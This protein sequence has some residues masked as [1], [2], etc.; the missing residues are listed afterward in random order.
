MYEAVQ[1]A[2]QVSRLVGWGADRSEFIGAE[3]TQLPSYGCCPYISSFSFLPLL[4]EPLL[5]HLLLPSSSSSSSPSSS[6]LL[7]PL[8]LLLVFLPPL[9][10]LHLLLDFVPVFSVRQLVYRAYIE[11]L[12]GLILPS[13]TVTISL[14]SVVPRGATAGAGNWTRHDKDDDD[15]DDDGSD[16]VTT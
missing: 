6:P 13:T 14:Q 3:Q 2:L 8:L 1:T 7:L 16:N 11:Y 10:L 12:C 4:P 9:L 5:H 15:D